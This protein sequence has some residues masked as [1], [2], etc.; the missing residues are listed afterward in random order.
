MERMCIEN[1]KRS[2]KENTQF[3]TANDGAFSLTNPADNA[4]Q[5]D[6][7][8]HSSILPVRRRLLKSKWQ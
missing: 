4:G 7:K 1:K 2:N 6:R 8:V 5:L 3:T